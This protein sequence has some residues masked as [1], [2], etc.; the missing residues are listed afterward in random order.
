MRKKA[1]DM[2]VEEVVDAALSSYGVYVRG[3]MYLT[4][5]PV[6]EGLCCELPV[7]EWKLKALEG[8]VKEYPCAACRVMGLPGYESK[9]TFFDAW[10]SDLDKVLILTRTHIAIDRVRGAVVQGKTFDIEFIAPGAEFETY[11]LYYT[12]ANIKMDGSRVEVAGVN[13]ETEKENPR[14]LVETLKEL[15][16]TARLQLGKRKTIGLGEVRIKSI[17][18]APVTPTGGQETSTDV[19]TVPKPLQELREIMGRLTAGNYRNIAEIEVI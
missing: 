11:L 14:N 8:G 12:H 19:K 10:P 9:V 1:G 5:N 3:G 13:A 16:S 18:V 17:E 2:E 15:A 7:P 4:C 6:I